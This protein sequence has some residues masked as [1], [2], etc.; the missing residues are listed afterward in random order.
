MYG[1]CKTKTTPSDMK[2]K[3]T[4]CLINNFFHLPLRTEALRDRLL[5]KLQAGR[6][7]WTT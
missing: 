3:I 7:G 4:T 5:K 1:L 6:F 2:A